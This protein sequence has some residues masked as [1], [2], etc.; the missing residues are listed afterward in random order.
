MSTAAGVSAERS[1]SCT[2]LH[3]ALR[4]KKV[5]GVKV[6]DSP[7]LLH[8]LATGRKSSTTGAVPKISGTGSG[9]RWR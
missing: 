7:H 3:C 1:H 6:K 4:K 5:N 8:E 9:Y 2:F